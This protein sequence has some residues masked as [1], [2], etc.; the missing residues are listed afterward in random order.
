MNTFDHNDDVQLK[1]SKI[2]LSYNQRKISIYSH[3]C[4]VGGLFVICYS[5]F[6]IKLAARIFENIM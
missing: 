4:E 5:I 3:G 2:Q 1:D 6:N